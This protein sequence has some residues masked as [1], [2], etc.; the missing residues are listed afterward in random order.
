MPEHGNAFL[1]NPTVFLAANAIGVQQVNQVYTP[2][3]WLNADDATYN[4][5]I[6]DAVGDNIPKLRMENPIVPFGTVWGSNLPLTACV[7]FL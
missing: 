1:A 6:R 3:N 7:Y 5:S 4:F 2:P